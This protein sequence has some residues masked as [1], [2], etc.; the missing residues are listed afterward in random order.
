M[1]ESTERLITQHIPFAEATA[2]KIAK[3]LPAWISFDD[4]RQAAFK[5]LCEAARRFD[6]QARAAFSTFAHARVR[7][8]VWDAVRHMRDI[9]PQLRSEAKRQALFAEAADDLAMAIEQ[10]G[11][12]SAALEE[13]VAK[14]IDVAGA[15]VLMA[16]LSEDRGDAGCACPEPQTGPA[17][18]PL[19]REETNLAVRAAIEALPA[20]LR[21]LVEAIV[22]G[23]LRQ[24]DIA[25]ARGCDKAVINRLWKEALC[26]LRPALAKALGER[27]S[28]RVL[29][30]G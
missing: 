28:P 24:V 1:S 11:G 27:G 29:V 10:S 30:R 2:R 22:Y 9:P 12:K 23:G 25:A 15:V 13:C 26:E 19:E 5:G 8:A 7:G 18:S 14:A 3:S 4:L 16:D 6:P 20:R 21:T 17:P